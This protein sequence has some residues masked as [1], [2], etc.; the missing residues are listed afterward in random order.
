MGRD[1]RFVAG[2]RSLLESW[3]NDVPSECNDNNDPIMESIELDNDVP[4]ESMDVP[5]DSREPTEYE[6]SITDVPAEHIQ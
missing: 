4:M 5:I 3:D 1:S 2:S 6:E